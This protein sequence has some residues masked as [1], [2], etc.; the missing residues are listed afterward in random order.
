MVPSASRCGSSPAHVLLSLRPYAR[1]TGVALPE[2]RRD[3]S[4]ADVGRRSVS[5]AGGGLRGL[6]LFFIV[7]LRRGRA[8]FK[9]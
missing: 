1:L 4:I 5:T 9:K 8:S 3:A 7:Q 6:A 2:P